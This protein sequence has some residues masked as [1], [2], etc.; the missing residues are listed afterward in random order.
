MPSP[1]RKS[2]AVKT[3]AHIRDKV[4]DALTQHGPATA[5]EVA[6]RLRL[7]PVLVRPRFSELQARKMIQ[8]T[9]DKRASKAS[10]RS[11]LKVWE[12]VA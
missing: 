9:G 11:P 5:D 6:K 8:T 1:A 12:V 2:A 7:D 10:P 4:L 3:P